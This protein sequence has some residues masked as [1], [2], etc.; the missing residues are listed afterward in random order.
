[1]LCCLLSKSGERDALALLALVFRLGCWC[2]GR[3]GVS[4][5]MFVGEGSALAEAAATRA[6]AGS[7]PLLILTDDRQYT[8]APA[9]GAAAEHTV[10]AAALSGTGVPLCSC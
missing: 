8:I 7:S 1:M 5:L 9:A 4:A 6:P 3:S 10:G 2:G